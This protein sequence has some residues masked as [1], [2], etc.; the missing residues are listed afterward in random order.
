MCDN[1]HMPKC[2]ARLATLSLLLATVMSLSACNL[3]YDNPPDN[4]PTLDAG[5]AGRSALS[6]ASEAISAG[7]DKL[8]NDAAVSKQVQT[9]AGV[10]R[11]QAAQRLSALGGVWNPWPKGTP[12]AAKPAPAPSPVPGTLNDLMQ[13]LVDSA[14]TACRAAANAPSG[15]DAALLAGVCVASRLDA[16]RLA[17]A[18]GV[19]VPP[20]QAA[21]ETPPATNPEGDPPVI[22]DESTLQSLSKSQSTLDY[23]RYRFETAAAHLRGDDRKWALDRAEQLSWDTQ[24][25][26]DL[27]AKDGRSAQYSLEFSKLTD[28]SAAISLLNQAD[29]DAF[30][31][32]LQVIRALPA[33]SKENPDRRSVWISAVQ[34]DAL[35]QQR[36][37]VPPAQIFVSLWP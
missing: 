4:L 24:K 14:E 8:A 30:V 7:A 2:A 35:S 29:A 16:S 27:G 10:V 37:G 13:M 31:A 12:P 6:R 32:H 26:V 33:A 5:Q 17:S 15:N 3:R 9:A 36:F 23:S 22:T 19:Q 18:G 21:I 34:S 28:T 1:G 25:L 11:D 20:P